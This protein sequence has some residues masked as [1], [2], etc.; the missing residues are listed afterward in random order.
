MIGNNLQKITVKQPQV[1]I[2]MPV[3][4]GEKSICKALDSILDQTFT[5]FE[6]VISDNASTDKTISICRE[7][8]KT[9]NRILY[10]RQPENCGAQNNL[11]LV[12]KEACGEYFMW[13][14]CDDFRSRDC[15]EFYLEHIKGSNAFFSTYNCFDFCDSQYTKHLNPPM[16]SGKQNEKNEDLLKF[17][18]QMCA[19]MIY[20][21][22]QAH[23]GTPSNALAKR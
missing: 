10:F 15:L 18:N 14:A 17:S 6:L 12:L 1:S 19:H 3:Y 21:F 4:N 16:L 7:Y 9:D 13:A 11:N 22:Q 8:L 5:D 20:G 23:G 2:G